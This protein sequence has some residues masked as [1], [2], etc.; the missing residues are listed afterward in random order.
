MSFLDC[1]CSQQYFYAALL[2]EAVLWLCPLKYQDVFQHMKNGLHKDF[3]SVRE[4]WALSDELIMWLK[5]IAIHTG[6]WLENDL[7]ETQN[8]FDWHKFWKNISFFCLFFCFQYSTS[9]LICS[10]QNYPTK[11]GIML[12]GFFCFEIY[13]IPLIS[14]QYI[15]WKLMDSWVFAPVMCLI[16]LQRACTHVNTGLRNVFILKHWMP[17]KGV[18]A[19]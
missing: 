2:K 18:F 8:C 6:S 3:F 4:C 7:Q 11:V 16:M 10:K 12:R 9:H 19:V 14:V 13:L 1:K 17:Q 5:A 15:M